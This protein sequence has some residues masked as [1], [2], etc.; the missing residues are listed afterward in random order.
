[1]RTIVGEES[2]AVF[3]IDRPGHPFSAHWGNDGRLA[4]KIVGIKS[5]GRRGRR[6]ELPGR[7]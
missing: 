1:M 7:L 3:V 4:G 2:R 5:K 6:I